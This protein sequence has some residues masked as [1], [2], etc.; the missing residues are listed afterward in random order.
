VLIFDEVMTGF[1]R[2]GRDASRR[3]RFGV[4]PDMIT[5]AKGVASAYVPLGGV[6]VRE[7][8]A[9]HFDD[10]PLMCGHTYSGHPL[11]MAAG[12]ATVSTMRSEGLFERARELEPWLRDGLSASRANVEVIGDAR[13]VGAF[14]R[15]SSSRTATPRSRWYPGTAATTRHRE[16][17]RCLAR[18]K[19]CTPSDATT[20]CW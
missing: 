4:V 11:T 18:T 12:L 8:L 9:R 13:G 14:R 10:T 17:A 1:G 20:C 16:A 15:S 7:D 3:N 6:L 2:R 19:G 5:F